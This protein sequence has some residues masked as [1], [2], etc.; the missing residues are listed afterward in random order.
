MHLSFLLWG[1]GLY[2]YKHKHTYERQM[3][4]TKIELS[5]SFSGFCRY[6]TRHIKKALVR[7]LEARNDE[8]KLLVYLTTTHDTPIAYNIIMSSSN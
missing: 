3:K 2:T 1:H 7:V 8:R 4:L 5:T 6:P